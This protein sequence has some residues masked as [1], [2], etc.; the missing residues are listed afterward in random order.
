MANAGSRKAEHDGIVGNYCLG[1]LDAQT[2]YASSLL[3]TMGRRTIVVFGAR[4]PATI[5]NFHGRRLMGFG[6]YRDEMPPALKHQ[7]NISI[8]I[9]IRQDFHDFAL[10]HL[11]G[12]FASFRVLQLKGLGV[13]AGNDRRGRP[14]ITANR[15]GKPQGRIA[16]QIGQGTP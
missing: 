11:G 9:F 7:G 8:R 10:S 5:A 6:T 16:G 15:A 3:E 4:Q 2:V 14:Q 1:R 12:E 13:G